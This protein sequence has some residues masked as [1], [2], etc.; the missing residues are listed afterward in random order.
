LFYFSPFPGNLK[1]HMSALS[2]RLKAVVILGLVS[3][4]LSTSGCASSPGLS[5]VDYQSVEAARPPQTLAKLW[6]GRLAG[7]TLFVEVYESGKLRSCLSAPPYYQ[8]MAGKYSDQAFYLEDGSRIEIE[9][10]NHHQMTIY[11]PPGN[12]IARLTA[13]AED[14]A[15]ID[16]FARA[17]MAVR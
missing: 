10:L 2:S 12:P 13:N 14:P 11:S 1:N 6:G 8:Q 16:C 3:A 9:P 15:A 17:A 4:G 5:L 7:G